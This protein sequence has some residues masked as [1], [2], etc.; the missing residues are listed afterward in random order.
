MGSIFA[1]IVQYLSHHKRLFWGVIGGLILFIAFSLSRL[2]FTEDI[3]SIIP[4][5]SR[6]EQVNVILKHSNL[7]DRLIF[8]FYGK[9]GQAVSTDSLI[10]FAE[11]IMAA[12][13]ADTSRV[14][15]V[16]FRMDESM[17][18]SLYDYFYQHLPFYLDS[19]DYARIEENLQPDN[20][21]ATLRKNFMSLVS[22]AG[23]ATKKYIFKDPL[24]LTPH[25]LKRFEKF[26]IDDNF[27]VINSSVFT[28]D[29]QHLLAFIMPVYGS[30][31][32]A[33]N[34]VLI[35]RIDQLLEQYAAHPTIGM[36]YYGGTAV[37][38]ANAHR[39]Q[40]DIML[41]VTAAM[42]ILTLLFFLMF[43]RI[44]IFAL[45]A[46]PVIL[47]AGLAL[48]VL[49][50]MEG[51]ISA[52]ALGVGAVLLG[53]AVD[54]S[55]HF[56]THLRDNR[57][58]KATVKSIAEPMIMSSLTTGGTFICLFVVRS[59][60]L[61]QLGLFAA[62][63]VL[64]AAFFVLTLVPVLLQRKVF[65][66]G[67]ER[68]YKETRLDRF[69]AY[70]FERNR[71]LVTLVA[72]I[73]LVMVFLP[74]KV[75]FNSDIG[76]LNYLSPKLKQAE[77]NLESFSAQ[78]LG[79]V[80]MVTTGATRD[81]ALQKSEALAADL[82]SL[83]AMGIIRERTSA[84][85]LLLSEA[86]QQQKLNQWNAF[87]QRMDRQQVKAQMIEYGQAF[88]FKE[89]AFSAFYQWIDQPFQTIQRADQAPLEQLFLK[90]YLNETEQEV[91]IITL[92]KVDQAHKK[93]FYA[94][95]E[96]HPDVLVFDRQYFV[97]QFF[98]VLNEDFSL[99]VA[100]S[101]ILVFVVLLL[102]FGRVEL[103]IVAFIPLFI[104]WNWTLGLM[105]LLGVEFNIFNV[106][107]STFIFGLGI[108]YCIFLMKGLMDEH[109]YGQF[110]LK[111]YRL[112]VILS[113]VTTIVGI[114]VLLFAQHPALKSIALVSVLGILSVVVVSFTLLPLLFRTLVK[115]K[116]KLRI[117]PI[118]AQNFT[119]SIST[120][121]FFVVGSLILTVTIPVFWLL[122]L[123]RKTVKYLFHGLITANMRFIVY[124]IGPVKQR[125]INKEKL[126]FDQPSVLIA[127]HLSHLD[128]AFLLMLHPKMIVMT[129]KWVWN[130]PF[131]GLAVRFAD[132]YPAFKGIDHD[133]AKL[134]KKVREG[135][136]I[137][138]F[139]EGTRSDDGTIKR[140]HQGAF[141]LADHLKL[142]I[143]PILIHGLDDCMHKHEFFMRGGP[144]TMKILDRKPVQH[145]EV[146][147]SY[148][149]QAKT[150]RQYMTA[151]FNLLKKEIETPDYY[152][153]QLFSRYTYKGPVLEWYMKVKVRLE[154]NYQF[155]ND[156]IPSRGTITD[157]GCGYGF[158]SGMLALTSSLRQIRGVDYDREKIAVAQQAF[159]DKDNVS[160][161]YKDVT[162]DELPASDVFVINDV[163]HYFP[164]EEQ[165]KL[166]E[167]CMHCLN[168]QGMI[169]IRDADSDLEERTKVTRRTEFFSTRFFRFNKTNYKE[170]SY[171]SGRAIEAIAQRNNF[172]CERIDNARFTSNV[173]FIL[174]PSTKKVDHATI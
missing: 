150:M 54:Y 127:N 6:I 25:A 69:A 170:L 168:D 28:A 107:I 163:L 106:I 47:G 75:H 9:E 155:F 113:A 88:H 114:G 86:V 151:E 174:R 10:A 117:Q 115:V 14:K 95:F 40:Y 118:T 159:V 87:W 66:S 169:I 149:P 52:I 39:I 102:F 55:L 8:H 131:Y 112:S 119:I 126:N 63:S 67:W 144:I 93:S 73:S 53:I 129:N 158:L 77:T 104:S 167:K 166:I 22:P 101:M 42:I 32:T 38:V 134:Q 103:A 1:T 154:K 60:A 100:V 96:Q 108:D 56:F 135:Y 3:T 141:W 43:R 160:F 23:V 172:S 4:N 116:G 30:S 5:D 164:R 133:V 146:R 17:Y 51:E 156:L 110:Q 90:N 162:R 152:R 35:E 145:I 27:T 31:N 153:P 173:V 140:F 111:P 57:N 148:R 33:K 58:V 61:N 21:Q 120:L 123:P 59:K 122:P 16:L 13:E 99:L 142:D 82:D 44:R 147:E 137:L 84:T 37:A 41:T 124:A 89:Q 46:F 85:D 68:K 15:E 80:Y 65:R 64:F 11:P 78:T 139:P 26:K 50:Y 92:L 94:H 165:D 128:L 157:I 24:S 45:M 91:S 125:F 70:D 2:S 130:S 132:Y 19:A 48:S 109:K 74:N 97:N 34:K 79:A 71:W 105:K 20:L 72:L 83:Q 136:S 12:L 7:S 143:Q 161:E 18:L 62:L 36:E 81:V 171:T 138:V 76:S 49:H 121:A 29:E 98:D